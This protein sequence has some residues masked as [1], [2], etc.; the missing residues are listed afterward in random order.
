VKIDLV[1][2]PER[3][4]GREAEALRIQRPRHDRP[5]GLRGVVVHGGASNQIGQLRTVVD[6]VGARFERADVEVAALGGCRKRERLVVRIVRGGEDGER[7]ASLAVGR[8][9]G[10]ADVVAVDPRREDA[11]AVRRQRRPVQAFHR[12]RFPRLGDRDRRGVEEEARRA[13]AHHPHR[14]E[15]APDDV[16]HAAQRDRGELRR[17]R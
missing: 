6:P 3:A 13:D 14:V 5:S 8:D 7:R 17:A 11:A 15:V 9:R 4:L 10:R 1:F 12:P 16:V 2:G